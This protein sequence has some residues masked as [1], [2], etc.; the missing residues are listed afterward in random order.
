MPTTRSTAV[1]ALIHILTRGSRPKDA[2]DRLAGDLDRRDRAFVMEI[3]YGVLRYRDTIDWVLVRFLKNPS[4]LGD[5][6]RNNLRIAVYQILFMRVP[7]WAAVNESVSIEKNPPKGSPR[8]KPALVNAVLRNVLRAREGLSLTAVSSDP[9]ENIAVTS[10]H[11]SWMIDRWIRRFGTE[12]AAGLASANNAI[13][14]MTIRTNTLR[15]SRDGLKELLTERGIEAAPTPRSPEGLVLRET[16]VYADLSFADGLFAV[17]DEASQLIGH[18]LGPSPG[19]RVLDACA[20]PGGKTGHIAQLMADRGE[21]VATEK[22]GERIRTLHETIQR[23]GLASVKAMRADAGRLSGTGTFDRVLLDAPCSATGVIRRN[24]DIKYR[25]R[26]TDLAEHRAKQTD[27]LHSVSALVRP[28]GV[29][30]YSV[31]SIEPEEGE[32]VVEAFLKDNGDFRI[33]EEAAFFLRDIMQQGFLRTYPHRDN[34]DGFFGVALC[35]VK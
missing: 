30:V 18:L 27:L 28:G 9:A 4:G 6:T 35:T 11:P 1:L 24:P 31:C 12:E 34:M 33:I 7:A 3:V 29:L 15:I 14:P 19:E 21:I 2:L 13:P 26:E 16:G 22:D 32:E 20:A 5:V 10:S 17:Q 23:F 8:G 25:L